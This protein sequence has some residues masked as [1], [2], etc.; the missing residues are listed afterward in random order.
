MRV[1]NCRLDYK[2]F[3]LWY[4]SVPELTVHAAVCAEWPS[5]F[6][7]RQCKVKLNHVIICKYYSTVAFD[8]CFIMITYLRSL[9]WIRK[10]TFHSKLLISVYRYK[11]YY[12]YVSKLSPR[13]RHPNCI[14]TDSNENNGGSARY[15]LRQ[16]SGRRAPQRCNLVGIEWMKKP[17][18]R[19][20][21][22]D[23]RDLKLL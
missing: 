15:N 7:I 19:V 17:R 9:R 18:Y 12:S 23:G 2:Q 5:V 20:I 1:V 11:Y 4:C 3:V 22:K 6:V 16:L 14:E 13:S 8:V 21:E 10:Q